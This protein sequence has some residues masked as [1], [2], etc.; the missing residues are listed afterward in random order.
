MSTYPRVL[1]ADDHRVVGEG[2]RRL[3]QPQFDIIGCVTDGAALVEAAEKHQPDVLVTDVSMPVLNGLDAIR[4]LRKT[5]N[6]VN[7]I[8]L[9]MHADPMLAAAAISA[10]ASG[11]VLKHSASDELI[12]AIR[13]VLAGRL[14]VTSL[15]PAE[16]TRALVEQHESPIEPLRTDLTRRQQE[17]LQ[18]VA[19][20]LS[21]KQIASR[22]QISRRTV[23]AHKYQLMRALGVHNIAALVHHAIRRGLISV[24]TAEF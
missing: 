17:I 1:I 8:V 6:R 13:E 18:L 5:G 24:P 15:L 20:G 21:I 10:G 22:L 14:Y 7:A 11:Y 23:E 3:L 2:I 19:E 9:T 16:G 4:A 12:L